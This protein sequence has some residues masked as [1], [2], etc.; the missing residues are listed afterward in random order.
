M[1]Y[2]L[3][4][5]EIIRTIQLLTQFPKVYLIVMHHS[6]GSVP[7]IVRQYPELGP[8]KEENY[9]IVGKEIYSSSLI[10]WAD[11]VIDLGTSA[12]FEAIKLGKPTLEP[13]YLH[14]TY[15]TVSHYFKDSVLLCRDHL[16]DTVR[17]FI[18]KGCEGFYNNRDRELFTSE[19]IDVPDGDVLSRYVKFLKREMGM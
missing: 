11:V 3:N 7:N 8:R 14:A 2:P 16:Y 18:E 4:W 9:E 5:K 6:R 12:A 1:A 15:T 19:V 17:R 13:E 10:D